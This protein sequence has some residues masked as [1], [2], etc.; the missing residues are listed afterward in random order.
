MRHFHVVD[1]PANFGGAN[2]RDTTLAPL[3]DPAARLGSE[4]TIFKRSVRD[5]ESLTST[6]EP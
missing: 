3:H 2:P 5:T 4:V 1:F 6:T